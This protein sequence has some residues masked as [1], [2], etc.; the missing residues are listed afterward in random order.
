MRSVWFIAHQGVV[1]VG[2]LPPR[3]RAGERRRLPPRQA[4]APPNHTSP[5]PRGSGKKDW[6]DA[7]SAGAKF[8]SDGTLRLCGTPGCTLHDH[9]AG[10]CSNALPLAKRARYQP[11]PPKPKQQKPCEPKRQRKQRAE[12]LLVD[13]VAADAPPPLSLVKPAVQGTRKDGLQRFYHVH[14][15]GTPLPDGPVAALTGGASDDEAGDDW[16]REEIARRTRSRPE[17]NEADAAFMEAWNAHV[18]S[19]KPRLVSDRMLPEAC[20]RFAQA[21]AAVLSDGA[22]L[23]AP[24]RAHLRVLWEHNLLHRDDVHDCLTLVDIVLRGAA[25][26]SGGAAVC[27]EC[28]RPRHESHCALAGRTRGAAAW[29]CLQ[30]IPAASWADQQAALAPA[31]RPG[32]LWEQA[33][34]GP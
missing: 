3:A 28:A 13:A 33:A 11:P 23:H 32:G 30:T 21:H 24:F 7:P 4:L 8:S 15:W 6:V 20:R 12:D 34:S 14:R 19:L 5:M 1:D 9:H 25:A 2:S 17:V 22:P 10:P 26:K 29:P 31:L 18:A 16:R 27:P